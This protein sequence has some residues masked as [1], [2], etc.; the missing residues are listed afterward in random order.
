MNEADTRYH[1][2]D[3][4]LRAKGYVSRDHITLETILTPPPVE[5]SGAKGRRRKGPGRT[6]YLLCVQVGG[7]PRPLPVAVLEAKKEGED[8]LKGMQQAKGYADCQRFDVKYVFSTNGHKYGEFDFVTSLQGGPFLFADFL[9]HLDLTARYAK[10]TGIDMARP[11]AAMLFQSD[12]PAWSLS[13]Y[14]QDAAIRA[15]IEKILLDGQAGKPPRVLLTLATGAGKTVIA[16]NLLWRLSQAGQLPKPALFLCDRDEL[17]EQAYTKLKAAFGDNARIVRTENGGNAA[18]NARIHVATYQ[19]LGLDDHEGFASFLTDHY[20]EDAFSVII[21]DECHRSAWGR[22]SEVLRRNPNATHIGLTATPRKLEE[23]KHASPEDQE[24][25]ANNRKYFGEP[26]YEYTLIQAQEDGYLA[27]CE[28]VRRK[29]SIDNA[30][31]T[32]AEVLK[33]GVRD[34]KTGQL[35]LESD[36]AKDEYTGK[37]FDDELFIELRTPR[38]CE[39]LFQLLCQNGGPEQKVIIF[40]TR[41]IH[42]D[43]VAQHM[44]N[45]Y[46]RWCKEQ[47]QTPKDHYAFKCMGGANNGSD[48]IEPMRGSGERA[49]IACTVDLL[50]AGVDIERLNAVV[51]FRYLQSPIKFYQMVGRGTRIHE[52]TQKYKFWLYD[53]TDV[54]QL[55]GTDFITKPPGPGG[56]D[57]GGGGEDP[58]GGDQGDGPAVAEIGGQSVIVNAQGRFILVNRDGRDTPIPVDEYRREVIERVVSEANNLDEFRA[59]WIEQQKRRQLIDHLLSDNFS[60]EVIREIDQM[61]EFDLYDFF[62]RHGYH[63]L[64]LKRAERGAL[65]ISH[66]QPWFDRMNPKAAIVLKGLGHQFAQG[67]TDALETTTLWEVPEIKLAGGLDALRPLGKPVQVMHEAKARLF[68]A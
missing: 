25:T 11:E 41:E 42:S 40:C 28:I 27:A 59:L 24:I 21:M 58:G 19:T 30:T 10:D 23:S 3:P 39:D 52:E 54:T 4:I 16:T 61:G 50:E 47:G 9:P 33:A 12:S 67:G 36:L 38:M 56:G 45:V 22:W 43:R 62:G 6:D 18:Q 7:M 13:R 48:M 53:Y 37:D 5:P 26:V 63:A 29:A 17:R 57:R 14:Y 34:I 44:N 20:G 65:F 60:P 35:L 66:H 8:P 46:V 49:F 55:F 1:L 2:I 32:K 15:A 68:G 51:F 31:F 64:A